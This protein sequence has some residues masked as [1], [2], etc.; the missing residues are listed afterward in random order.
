MIINKDNRHK[1]RAQI[2]KIM[3]EPEISIHTKKTHKSKITMGLNRIN[4]TIYR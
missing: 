3:N 1:G 2:I 4:N